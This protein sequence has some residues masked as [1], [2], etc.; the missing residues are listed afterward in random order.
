MRFLLFSKYYLP[1]II[2]GSVLPLIPK[3]Q[4]DGLQQ[5]LCV[6]MKQQAALLA[7]EKE[8]IGITGVEVLAAVD[9]AG[10]QAVAEHLRHIL[11]RHF[12]A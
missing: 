8:L 2:E 9:L 10:G 11:L 6:G 1:Y 3:G 4:K 12:H 7:P 5:C